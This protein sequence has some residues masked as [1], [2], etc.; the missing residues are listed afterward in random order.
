MSKKGR[1]SPKPRAST[2]PPKLNQ[3]NEDFVETLPGLEIWDGF[4]AVP[5]SRPKSLCNLP[6]E[7]LEEL[8]GICV[9]A[10]DQSEKRYLGAYFSGDNDFLNVRLT[11]LKASLEDAL[12]LL[13][14][15]KSEMAHQTQLS[16][17]VDGLA[18]GQR[19]K[20]ISS[21][22]PSTDELLL[23]QHCAPDIKLHYLQ[24]RMKVSGEPHRDLG[25]LIKEISLAIDHF[26]PN[27]PVGALPLGKSEPAT[28]FFDTICMYSKDL[29][30][31]LGAGYGARYSTNAGAKTGWLIDLL[32]A[33]ED[34]AIAHGV[35][36]INPIHSRYAMRSLSDTK[37][38]QIIAR[39]DWE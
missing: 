29:M 7:T 19:A 22:T 27:P 5:A 31:H 15:E 26:T 21:I 36:G 20:I 1:P 2:R 33:A 23:T 32:R 28:V 9:C 35:K 30:Q 37:L 24:N 38:N 34:H 16:G 12:K 39:Y 4:L 25:H 11:N 18:A 10:H 17:K 6:S 8:R 14:A 3:I 13:L